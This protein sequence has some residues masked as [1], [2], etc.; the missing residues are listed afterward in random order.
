MDCPLQKRSELTWE[1]TFSGSPE[2][3]QIEWSS[4]VPHLSRSDRRDFLTLVRVC[5]SFRLADNTRRNYL[6]PAV[7]SAMRMLRH[8]GES[9]FQQLVSPLIQRLTMPKHSP[10]ERIRCHAQN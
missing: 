4:R 8:W 7:V 1:F 5:D 2:R 6:E 10:L 3:L 9:F